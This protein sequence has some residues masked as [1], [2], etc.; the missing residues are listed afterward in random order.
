ML[1]VENLTKHFHAADGGVTALERLSLDVP[2]GRFVAVI[3]PSGCGK[4]TLFNI[5]GGL[6]DGYEGRVTIDG[7][8]VAGVHRDVGMVFQ[9]ESTFP[10]LTTLENVAFPLDVAL[11]HQ[12]LA[13]VLLGFS[14]AHWRGFHGE[15]P[16]PTDV[17]VRS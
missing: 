3:G 4:S 1:T 13:L 10:W 5:V 7:K 16:R 9:E 8:T 17:A 14:V 2:R 15:Y 12:G 6:V 11:T